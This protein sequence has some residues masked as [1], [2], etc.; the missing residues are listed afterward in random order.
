M[1]SEAGSSV[2]SPSAKAVVGAVGHLGRLLHQ[3]F[4][5][6]RGVGL[7]EVDEELGIEIVS[8]PVGERVLELGEGL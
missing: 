2:F 1:R 4:E 5:E 8:A 7:V 6:R 3:F